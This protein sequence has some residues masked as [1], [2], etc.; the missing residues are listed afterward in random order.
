MEQWIEKE[1]EASNFGD[2]RLSKRY[3][4]IM[5]C[6]SQ[7]PQE[8]IPASSRGWSE[9]IAAYRFIHNPEVS[10]EKILAGHKQAT[11]DRIESSGS[12]VILAIQDTTSIDMT[13]HRSS[14]NLGHIENGAHR[15]LFIH[16]TQAVTPDGVNLGLID[17]MIWTRDVSTK[18][19][20]KDRKQKGIEEKESYRWLLSYQSSNRVAE[21]FPDKT[22]VSV[23]DREN[24]IYEVFASANAEVSKSKILIR[25][26]QNRK[27][28]MEQEETKLLWSALETTEELGEKQL[29]L[30]Q[31][32][33]HIARAAQLSVKVKEV[34]LKAPYRK[35]TKLEDVT[36]N[37][38][39][40]EEKNA[41]NEADK[42]EWLLLTTI[43]I[44]SI[45][46]A[47]RIIDYYSCRWQIEMYFRVLKGG[48][49]VEKLQLET[50]SS[51]ENAIA[52]YMVVSW[53][54][55]YL[56]MLGRQCPDLLFSKE[57]LAAIY[58]AKK[59]PI[60]KTT[61][62]LNEMIIMIATVGGYLNRKS[63]KPPGVKVFWTGLTKLANYAYMYEQ[64]MLR[65]DVY[66]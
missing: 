27:L 49:E 63:D 52:V 54:I 25:A 5:E 6:F 12:S 24:D 31:T 1:C 55:Q 33:H 64:M 10:F 32:K 43:S 18:G 4:I 19:K 21:Q 30:A 47:L 13:N 59:K 34:T 7:S 8:S 50:V 45:E 23:G 26:S 9:T 28:A 44:S 42:I 39:L 51:I 60:P 11:L 66:N 65:N 56:L 15:G 2:K 40:V 36:L 38:I 14:D 37:A 35:A 3:K 57:E 48:C 53:R 58:V 17:S 16:P 46:D 29:T 41:P 62:Q 22:I 61:P 20:K